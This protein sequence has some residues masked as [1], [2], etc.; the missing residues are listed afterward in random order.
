MEVQHPLKSLL[1][2]KEQTIYYLHR[3]I[4]II[5]IYVESHLTQN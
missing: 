4:Y 5:S 3:H 2:M 1:L